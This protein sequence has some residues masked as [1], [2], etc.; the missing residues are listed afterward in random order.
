MRDCREEPADRWIDVAMFMVEQEEPRAELSDSILARLRAEGVTQLPRRRPVGLIAAAAA[1][2]VVA[3]GLGVLALVGHDGR[4]GQ[5]VAERFVSTPAVVVTDAAQ[6]RAL[7]R[8]TRSVRVVAFANGRGA[9]GGDS[10]GG[11]G[12]S[13]AAVLELL[14]ALAELPALVELELG[15]TPSDGDK[16]LRAVPAFPGPGCRDGRDSPR[17]P[18]T[19]IR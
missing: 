6:V 10:A 17:A 16:S 2:V 4:G 3:A 19:Y 18:L 1:A 5:P 12:G 8:D 15:A 9:R 14:K 11:G 13:D 7:P